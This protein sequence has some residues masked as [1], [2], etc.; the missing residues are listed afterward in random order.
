MHLEVANQGETS[1]TRSGK[2][3]SGFLRMR[4]RMKRFRRIEI[5]G[6]P[7]HVASNRARR[8]FLNIGQRRAGDASVSGIENDRDSLGRGIARSIFLRC[9][10]KQHQGIIQ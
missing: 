7:E 8:E 5:A 10:L 9:L 4:D 2:S 6:G 3:A 1:K